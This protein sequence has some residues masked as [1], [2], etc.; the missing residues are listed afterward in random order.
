M[1]LKQFVDC[2]WTN[3][4]MNK[5]P[6]Q[7]QQTRETENT[8]SEFDPKIGPRMDNVLFRFSGLYYNLNQSLQVLCAPD[9]CSRCSIWGSADRKSLHVRGSGTRIRSFSPEP[10]G[11]AYVLSPLACWSLQRLQ[12]GLDMDTVTCEA[13]F[14]APGELTTEMAGCT[15]NICGT[16]SSHPWLYRKV[17]PPHLGS[18]SRHFQGAIFWS[19]A[20]VEICTRK[21]ITS[22][23][24]F[25]LFNAQTGDQMWHQSITPFRH[26]ALRWV[27][28]GHRHSAHREA[29]L[30]LCVGGLGGATWTMISCGKGR[31]WGGYHLITS[32]CLTCFAPAYLCC[33]QDFDNIGATNASVVRLR[34][35]TIFVQYSDPHGKPKGKKTMPDC[36]ENHA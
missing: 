7:V 33:L 1:I 14:R 16:T 4:M 17:L 15:F 5:D 9:M 13:S 23:M 2:I 3:D 28:L 25:L 12:V 31:C 36:I 19:V 18:D 35:E 8:C 26:F 11:M 21:S 30:Q 34:L 29:N 20:S 27:R 6:V 32:W 10:K 22:W 24:M